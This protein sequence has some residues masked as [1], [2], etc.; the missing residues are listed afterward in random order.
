MCIRDSAVRLTIATI[1]MT[2]VLFG[3]SSGPSSVI[4]GAAEAV[5]DE[6]SIKA[7]NTLVI[8]GTGENF[9]LGQ[10]VSPEAPLPKLTVSSSKRS[11]DYE[12]G[13]WRLEQARTPTYVTAN[14]A[15]N[16]PQ[17]L[18]VDGD[19]AYN[20]GA[21]GMATRAAEQ[22]ANDSHSELFHQ[23]IGALR[24]AL[25]DGAQITNARKEGD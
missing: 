3:C 11:I 17:V 4:N 5:G 23:P 25:A 21:N 10:N 13:R 12:K 15:P 19:V 8:E 7:V 18:G 22:V 9:N 24:A 16:Q 14:T 20:V 2:L 1:V 6:A